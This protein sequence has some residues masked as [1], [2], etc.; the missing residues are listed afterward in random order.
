MEDICDV[1]HSLPDEYTGDEIYDTGP[2]DNEDVCAKQDTDVLFIIDLSASMAPEIQAV[3]SFV[4][5]FAIQHKDA[6]Y[7]NWA[8]IIGPKNAGEKPGNHNF[9]YLASNLGPIDIF[10]FAISQVLQYK[11]IGQYEMLY[12]ALYLSIRNLSSFLPYQWD[13]LLWPVWVGNVIDESVPPLDEFYIKW[14]EKS[15]RI[16]IVFTDEPGQSFLIPASK[17]GK[18]YNTND[19]ITQEKLAMM[20]D[21]IDDVRLYTFTDPANAQPM[22]SWSSLTSITFGSSFE[23]NNDQIDT[24]VQLEK[25]FDEEI[26]Y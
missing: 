4:E 23:I 17:V 20:L 26:C 15:K 22:G 11:M 16:I 1:P 7:I 25:I 19:T 8:L 10:Q 12:D 6:D 24:S 14:R 21:S 13:E 5:T 2:I 9:L 3:V 18:S